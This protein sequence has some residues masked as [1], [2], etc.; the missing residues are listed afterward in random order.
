MLNNRQSETLIKISFTIILLGYFLVW[1]PQPVV[2]LSFIGLEIGEWVKFIPQV[3]QG[4][5]LP[6]RSF[7]YLPPV[8]LG[9]M[10]ALW[11]ARWSNRRWK[12]WVIRGTALLISL[13]AL[14]A[15]ESFRDE[16]ISQ[17]VLRLLFI[18]VAAIA[19]LLATVYA[20]RESV[21]YTVPW[22][23]F[24]GLGLIGALLPLWIFLAIRPVAGEI[25]GSKVGFGVGILLNILG[26][27]LLV[28]L[29]M[30]HLSR[31]KSVSS[32]KFSQELN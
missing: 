29:G 13:L 9:A 22:A 19:I 1:L 16:P 6:S 30:I 11:T 32:T 28:A 8:T 17:W 3:R 2:G 31:S 15:I 5:I 25:I 27:G 18:V 20:S 21:P 10:M 23:Y 26:H 12:T 7:F 24:V 14:P 4:D